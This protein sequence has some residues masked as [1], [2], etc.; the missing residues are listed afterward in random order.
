M[1][2]LVTK[3]EEFSFDNPF[4]DYFMDYEVDHVDISIMRKQIIEIKYDNFP[5]TLQQT[6][7]NL[8]DPQK[9][10]LES[11]QECFKGRAD[12]VAYKKAKKNNC[13]QIKVIKD[14]VDPISI[15]GK[16]YEILKNE[17]K[18][19]IDIIAD[20]LIRKYHFITIRETNEIL[21]F[22][23]KIYDK[24]AAES[25]IKEETEKQIENCREYQTNEVINKIKRKTYRTLETFDKDPSEI[26]INN[27]ILNIITKEVRPHTHKHYS[28]ILFP[29]NYK[30][31]EFEDIKDNLKDTLFWKFLTNSFTVDGKFRKEDFETVLEIMAS[32]LIRQNIDQKAFMFLGSGENGKSVLMGV[33]EAILGSENVSNTALQDLVNEKVMMADLQGKIAN[34]FPDLESEELKH[35]GKLKALICDEPMTVRKLYQEP[36]KLNPRVKSLFSCNL[37]PKV[38]DQ[39]HGFFRRWIIVEWLRNFENDPDKIDNLKNVICQNKEEINLVFSCLVKVA[40]KLIKE[41]KFTHTKP[42]KDVKRMWLENS[43]PLESWIRNYTKES[44]N[45]TTLRAADDFYKETMFEKGETPV[46]M[47]KLNLALEEQYEKTKSNGV[48]VWLNM[49]LKKPIQ[50]TLKESIL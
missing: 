4:N 6:Y 35:T 11:I 43:N 8:D 23:G 3:K 5:K 18:E 49:E 48:R 47:H 45:S 36:F 30:E 25:M 26:T 21:L 24:A 27:G 7:D 46:T 37:F 22:N 31:P 17:D 12:E 34:I 28:R 33:I 29:D 1:S 38:N 44:E 42:E 41:Q 2:K 50:E 15:D 10:I 40:G 14:D 19:N 39:S 9:L 13:F 16:S 32:F 20:N